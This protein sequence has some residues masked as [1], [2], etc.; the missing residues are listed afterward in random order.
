MTFGVSSR[1]ETT[2]CV[3]PELRNASMSLCASGDI[4]VELNMSVFIK[5]SATD[6]LEQ[7][8]PQAV[9]VYPIICSWVLTSVWEWAPRHWQRQELQ[10][11]LS[12]LRCADGRERG[13]SGRTADETMG[14]R[15][16]TG[17]GS[18]VKGFTLCRFRVKACNEEPTAFISTNA[19]GSVTMRGAGL[20]LPEAFDLWKLCPSV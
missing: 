16:T 6:A 9:F 19:C 12:L 2:H 5:G 14:P 17:H 7:A 15:A 18:C 8:D 4:P 20:S 3:A 1:S 11:Y 10:Q 13:P